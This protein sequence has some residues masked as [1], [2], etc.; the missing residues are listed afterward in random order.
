MD[1][2]SAIKRV[3]GGLD[4][5]KDEMIAVMRGIMSGASTD[6]QNAAFLVGLQMKGVKAVEILGGA[7]VMR[8]LATP[9][10]LATNSHLVDT[11][12][13]GGS[14]ADKFNISTA[15]A[16]VAAA[17]GA[18]VAKH[19]NRGATSVSGSADVLE[20]A[21]LNLSLTADQ[22]ART[23]EEV[24]VGFMFAPAHHGAMKHVTTA[25]REIG[26]RTIFNLLGPLTNPA[27]A[28]NQVMGVFDPDWIPALLNVFKELGSNHVLIVSS[29]DGLDE[30]SISAATHVGEL[31]NGELST[32][33]ISPAD[34]G[35]NQY[36]NF[37]MLKIDSA[38]ASL[39]M[40]MQALNY[41]K[42]A[43]GDIVAL[44]AG[45]AI[46]VAGLAT[47][48][49]AGVERAQAVMRSG[50]ALDKLDQLVNFTQSIVMQE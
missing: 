27:S 46:Y 15:A 16:I 22:V 28:P 6:A 42:Q 40:L 35:I 3:T 32:Y 48:L 2:K 30:I 11:C 36:D 23:I 10:I 44:N 45:A 39:K 5:N 20:A 14:G 50:E 19:G 37:D 25:R 18:R 24:G 9:V 33:T 12:G 17:A 43:A 29:A 4:L 21:G 1:I 38:Q 49:G 26:V 47:D 7:T 8:E 13:T 31:K 41:A 34:I